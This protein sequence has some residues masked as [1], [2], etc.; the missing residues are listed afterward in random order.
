M[1]QF[2]TEDEAVQAIK[3]LISRK[4]FL[5]ASTIID[6]NLAVFPDSKVLKF[7]S[8]HIALETKD[9]NTAISILESLNAEDPN[10]RQI[11]LPLARAWNLYGEIEKSL[12][13]LVE[14]ESMGVDKTMVEVIRA[15]V[16]ERRGKLDLLD[17]CV[18]KL[19]QEAKV[20]NIR[21]RALIARKEYEA[22]IDLL[23]SDFETGGLEIQDIIS[24]QFTLTK[25][26]DRIGEYDKAWC[27][28]QKAH[29]LDETKFD[30]VSYFEQYEVMTEFMNADLVQALPE[31]PKTEMEP[32]FIVGNPRSGTSLLEQILSMH[33]DVENG[34][35][36][37]VG[38]S[39]Q[40]NLSRL[41]DSFHSWPHNMIDMRDDDER[42]LSE[43]YIAA[44]KGVEDVGID[45][46]IISNKALNLPLQLGFMSKILPSSR[47]VM[48]HR[49]PLD[50]AVSCYTTNLLV[51]GHAYTNSLTSLGNTWVARKKIADH[52]MKVLSIPMIELHYENLVAD[53]RGET[54]RLI[55]F[56]DLPWQEDCMEFHKSKRV[57]RTISYDQVNKKMY[58]TSSGRWKNYEK[59]LG[60]LIDVVSDYI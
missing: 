53:Q 24:N 5:N 47:A 16:Y 8:S 10:Q 43:Q 25:A 29:A 56:L 60:P 20:I 44:N 3:K 38:Y 48:L 33:P 1:P 49:H 14:A 55:K 23:E 26:Y 37:C 41:T 9:F 36:M 46:K 35:E 4:L 42:I 18:S 28:A 52:W 58:N 31:G 40:L 7:L 39:M 50:N 34:G 19:P 57:A 51:S 21:A 22:A 54:E 30:E 27:A 13:Y 6:E 2:Y 12:G 17:E 11:L 45:K 59:H 15:E 32:L